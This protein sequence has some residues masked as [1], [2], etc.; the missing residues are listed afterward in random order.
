MRRLLSF[1]VAFTISVVCYS[2]A[3]DVTYMHSIQ[4]IKLFLQG[5]QL[6]Y[7]IIALNSG[8]LLEL[9]FDDMDGRVKNYFY[10]FQLCNAD[11]TPVDLSTFDYLKGF[12]E[13]RLNQYRPSS[14]SQNKY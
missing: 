9:H 12:S 7:P 1:W 6:A 3:P 13:V 2:Q 8:D 4:G 14:V 11:W 5:N 10:T